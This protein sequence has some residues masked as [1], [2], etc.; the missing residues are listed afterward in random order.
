MHKRLRKG[1]NHLTEWYSQHNADDRG[2]DA[3][4]LDQA[5]H[6]G[7]DGEEQEDLVVIL[8]THGAGA[9]ALIGALTNQPV[10]LDVGMASLT[11]AV[12]KPDAP[13]LILPRA[14]S[15]SS[16]S[17][18]TDSGRATPDPSQII[19][20]PRRRSTLDIGLSSVYEMKIVASSEHLRPA[21]SNRAQAN[22]QPHRSH[23]HTAPR[24]QG[25]VP[26][27][28]SRSA[29][30]SAS[31]SGSR[32]F[33]GIGSDFTWSPV[34]RTEPTRNNTSTALGSI[35]RPS[36]QGGL[37]SR[38]G[39]MTSSIGRNDEPLPVFTSVGLWQPPAA[40]TSTPPSISNSILNLAD[41]PVFTPPKE[42]SRRP[43][44]Q[45]N[46]IA[47]FSNSPP[48]SRSP[49]PHIR[50]SQGVSI[51]VAASHAAAEIAE[52][53]AKS[54]QRDSVLGASETHDDPSPGTLTKSHSTTNLDAED[55]RL[56]ALPIVP[57]QLPHALRRGLSQKGLWG[58][59][60]AGDDV[61]RRFDLH[62][63]RRWSENP[64]AAARERAEVQSAAAAA[65]AAAAS[66][67]TPPLSSSPSSA[68][69]QRDERDDAELAIE[70]VDDLEVGETNNCGGLEVPVVAKADL[71]R[72]VSAP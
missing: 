53:D 31:R 63:K 7:D 1:V 49:S 59:Q 12:R 61:L 48:D 70:E 54:T 46:R 23:E 69:W 50:G 41:A 2:E 26:R 22:Q 51:S 37:P 13:S 3:L 42:D 47:D 35:R 72:E 27:S 64:E 52:D 11:M 18:P 55:D 10:L 32:D 6:H 19:Y 34:E 24:R 15:I 25:S 58:S 71:R 17:S 29:S 65:A 20:G 33:T 56:S 38:Q 5:D 40:R 39:S 60:P 66:P 28:G 30:R 45:H 43:S 68:V 8:V 16:M 62:P 57:P 14:S 9:N 4:G 21:D 44:I 36:I 67:P